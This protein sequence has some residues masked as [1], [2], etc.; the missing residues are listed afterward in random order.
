MKGLRI[1]VAGKVEAKVVQV[2]GAAPVTMPSAELPQALQRGVVDGALMNPWTAQ[3]RGIEQ[4]CKYMLIYPMSCQST[5]IYVL[6]DKWNSWP[7]DV[8]ELLRNT[9]AKWEGRYIGEIVNDAQLDRE[10]IPKYEKAGMKAVHL[11]KD[12]TQRF[13]RAIRPVLDWWIRQVGGDVGKKALEYAGVEI[14]K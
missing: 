7:E 12:E 2:L 13:D 5:P 14:D 3:G 11:T 9:A 6:R 4:F 8:R 1:R 10:V